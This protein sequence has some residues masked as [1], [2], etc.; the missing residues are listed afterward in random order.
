[1]KLKANPFNL[2]HTVCHTAF[3]TRE[4]TVT[5]QPNATLA[6]RERI[7]RLCDQHHQEWLIWLDS[8]DM[9][10]R[11][12]GV[13]ATESWSQGLSANEVARW[14]THYHYLTLKHGP[15]VPSPAPTPEL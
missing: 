10:E 8:A 2:S 6:N 4:C 11:M 13:M 5:Y 12:K 15:T 9:R 7:I 3:C 1:M 14:N